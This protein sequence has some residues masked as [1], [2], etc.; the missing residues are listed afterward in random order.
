MR[1]QI[2][3]RDTTTRFVVFAVGVAIAAETTV[4][5]A[6]VTRLGV[7]VIALFFAP[8]VGVTI[9]TAAL[10]ARPAHT[11]ARPTASGSIHGALARGDGSG[12]HASRVPISDF[13]IHDEGTTQCGG[14]RTNNDED[15]RL[16]QTISNHDVV[17]KLGCGRSEV[18]RGISLAMG[19]QR[20]SSQ[21]MD[22]QALSEVCQKKAFLR[23]LGTM[24]S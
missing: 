24:S 3:G 1:R 6:A 22:T 7:A 10:A 21:G 13:T 9:A 11:D 16:R 20:R 5:I 14:A 8:R 17:W 18:H 23:G 12:I 4:R 19:M 15:E 2:A